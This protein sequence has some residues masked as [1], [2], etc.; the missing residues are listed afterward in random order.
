M[1]PAPAPATTATGAGV[2]E[3]PVRRRR[4]VD[5]LATG[6]EKLAHFVSTFEHMSL[7]KIAAVNDRLGQL[8][9]HVGFVEK[10]ISATRAEF[11][12]PEDPG[13]TDTAAGSLGD[14]LGA[15]DRAA[16]STTIPA[17]AAAPLSLARSVASG[18]LKHPADGVDVPPPPP[19]PP[20]MDLPSSG[21]ETD[22][23]G[24]AALPPP[25]PPPPLAAVSS[26]NGVEYAMPLPPPPPPTDANLWGGMQDMA[27]A[28][29]PPPPPPPMADF[30]G[31]PAGGDAGSLPP[32]PPPPPDMFAWS[33]AGMDQLPLPPP[34]PPPPPM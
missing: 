6:I 15:V 19:P 26:P 2:S 5:D 33:T 22:L 16:P 7:N 18:S 13:A 28:L 31:W 20:L 24:A 29:P 10:K 30:G 3:D 9:R 23:V 12:D 32:P 8:E 21:I 14:L 11:A 34:P 17:V 1:T 27:Y 4:V 25:P